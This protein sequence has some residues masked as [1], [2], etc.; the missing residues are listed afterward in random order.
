VEDLFFFFLFFF[1]CFLFISSS[2]GVQLGFGFERSFVILGVSED[3]K[4]RA[5]VGM[6]SK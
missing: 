2:F 1:F 3:L 4:I 5:V 6:Q